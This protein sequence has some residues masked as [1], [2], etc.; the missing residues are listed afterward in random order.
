MPTN[1]LTFFLC[2]RYSIILLHFIDHILSLFF[3][4]IYTF[5]FCL[6]HFVKIVMNSIYKN[7][8]KH[9]EKRIIY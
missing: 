4:G 2:S 6:R 9:R 5:Y 3:S 8:E 7:R 1:Y